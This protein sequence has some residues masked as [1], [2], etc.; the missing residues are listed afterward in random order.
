M[1]KKNTGLIVLVIILVITTLTSVGYITYEKFFK[2][3][4]QI[5]E[6][7]KEENNSFKL[8]A[9]N[10]K[11][12]IATYGVEDETGR[13]LEDSDRA[14]VFYGIKET[15]YDVSINN[16]G[17]LMLYIMCRDSHKYSDTIKVILEKLGY[18]KFQV[19]E[20]N[21]CEFI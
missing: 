6:E 4:E 16:K 9:E 3:K 14:T 13:V 21:P 10:M 12:K 20:V 8:F 18:F 11:K 17:E 19:S 2:E 7:K 15:V 5:C 1:E